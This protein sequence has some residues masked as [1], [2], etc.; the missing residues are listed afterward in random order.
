MKIKKNS[1][2]HYCKKAAT[3]RDHIVPKCVVQGK[4]D[5][6]ITNFVPCCVTCNTRKANKRSNC[7]CTTCEL[8]WSVYGPIFKEIEV[9]DMLGTEDVDFTFQPLV[10]ESNAALLL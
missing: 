2:C 4:Y 8:A 10:S 3:T 1:N 9:I 6:K 5:R 7:R